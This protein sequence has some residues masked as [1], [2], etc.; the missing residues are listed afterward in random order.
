MR[1][2]VPLPNE[3]EFIRNQRIACR[4]QASWAD[5]QNVPK[6]LTREKGAEIAAKFMTTFYHV[7]IGALETREFQTTPVPF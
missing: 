1:T 4:R 3:V 5:E 7:Q 6:A 2:F